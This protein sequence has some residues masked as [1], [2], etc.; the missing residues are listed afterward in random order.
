MTKLL[1]PAAFLLALAACDERPAAPSA[2][3][4]AALDEAEAMLDAEAGNEKGPASKP[5]DPDSN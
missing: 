5:A 4:N 1:A 2:K 3:Q